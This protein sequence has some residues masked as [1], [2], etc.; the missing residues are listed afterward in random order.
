MLLKGA[1]AH[2]WSN[3]L[4]TTKRVAEVIRR[5]LQKDYS[6]SH[7][8]RILTE[9]LG[10]SAQRPARRSNDNDGE[11]ARWLREDYPR[12]LER[13]AREAYLAFVDES[14]FLL[15][16]LLRKTFAPRG[17]T[18]V[19]KITDPHERISAIGAMTISPGYRH[20]GFAFHLLDD[21]ANFQGESVA[22][23]VGKLHSRISGPI[24]MLWDSYVIHCAAAVQEYCSR[25]R[26][27]VVEPFPA[28]ALKLNPVDEVR[29]YVKYG[30]L[31]NFTPPNL[32]EL[33]RRV[34]A[35]LS[36]VQERPSLLRALFQR[37]RLKLGW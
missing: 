3:E 5:H 33:R 32:A 35:E 23:F 28:Y 9:D 19:S 8:W 16:P 26:E 17:C 34:T 36:R 7:V 20:Y 1:T 14:G 12:I 13:A 31:P 30:R 4:W 18:P 15:E 22:H 11:I 6:P 27:L 25:H 37:T 10:W 29:C 2:G 21:N 24:T